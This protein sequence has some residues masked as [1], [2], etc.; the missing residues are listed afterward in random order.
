LPE[1]ITFRTNYAYGKKEYPSHGTFINDSVFDPNLIRIDNQSSF[2][3]S[4]TKNFD[5]GIEDQ[6]MI[7]LSIFYNYL[8]NNSNSFW[9]NFNTS[10]ID[11]SF[12]YQF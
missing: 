7:S 8:N 9:Y 5:V 10:Q 12:Q 4:L 11:F 3:V 2:S 6:N 1:Q